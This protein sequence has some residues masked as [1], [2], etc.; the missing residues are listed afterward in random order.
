[1]TW[2]FPAINSKVISI[3]SLRSGS[4]G[5]L[6]VT[7]SVDSRKVTDD[8]SSMAPETD[9][10]TND[11]QRNALHILGWVV[12][13]KR[14]DTRGGEA[15]VYTATVLSADARSLELQGFHLEDHMLICISALINHNNSVM[16]KGGSKPDSYITDRTSVAPDAYHMSLD[17]T[18]YGKTTP[19]L[20]NDNPLRAC[21]KW[22]Q[23]QGSL[24]AVVGL[25]AAGILLSPCIGALI[26]ITYQD[27]KQV[28]RGSD[29]DTNP[30][31]CCVHQSDDYEM[32][33]QES[34]QSNPPL[35]LLEPKTQPR[36]SS[37]KT[38]SLQSID[39]HM[40]ETQTGNQGK[41]DVIP[42]HATSSATSGACTNNTQEQ[43]YMNSEHLELYKLSSVSYDVGE[44]CYT[45]HG[46]DLGAKDLHS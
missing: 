24:R 23:S 6:L 33:Y 20:F 45:N 29:S 8:A 5:G 26:Y 35:E 10:L 28:R 38:S 34:D 39:V 14:T 31:I 42:C 46:M 19:Y 22:R 2:T 41:T 25:V 40:V 44:Y 3:D 13:Y 16:C 36:K 15:T 43:K 4:D 27:R 32:Q 1:M 11:K 30:I 17:L 37:S 9:S 21:A 12:I 7:W 18:I